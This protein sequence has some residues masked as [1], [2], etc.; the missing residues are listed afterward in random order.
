LS[1]GV[2]RLQRWFQLSVEW[3]P[4]GTLTRITIQEDVALQIWNVLWL[5][6][7]VCLLINWLMS[8]GSLCTN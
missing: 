8:N 2:C 7:T 4:C 6:S 3:V 1:V 5:V